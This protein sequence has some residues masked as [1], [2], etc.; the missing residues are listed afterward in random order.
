[1][2]FLFFAALHSTLGENATHG[3][4]DHNS[5]YCIVCNPDASTNGGDTQDEFQTD[6][7]VH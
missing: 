7:E 2:I 3:L 1:M 4:L 5:R 6:E